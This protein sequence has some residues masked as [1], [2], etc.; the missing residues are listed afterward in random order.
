MNVFGNYTLSSFFSK[1]Q[2]PFTIVLRDVFVKGN[3]S[4]EVQRDGMIRTKD[5]QM[6]ISFG[7][8]AVDFQNLGKNS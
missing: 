1:A 7:D 2:G 4:L 8:M 6:D 5:I 3:A